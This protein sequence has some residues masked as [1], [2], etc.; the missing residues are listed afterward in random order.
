MALNTSSRLLSKSSHNHNDTTHHLSP[1]TILPLHLCLARGPR[2]PALLKLTLI[3]APHRHIRLQLLMAP[4][5][6][7]IPH[8]ASIDLDHAAEDHGRHL[9]VPIQRQPARCKQATPDGTPYVLNCTVNP[10]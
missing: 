3:R 10:R 5:S 6:L 9:N 1:P 2:P 4:Y 8:H 7:V